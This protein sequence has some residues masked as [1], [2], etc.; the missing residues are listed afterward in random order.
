MTTLVIDNY[1]S[2]TFNVVQALSSLGASVQ[3][4]R[5]DAL[6]LQDAIS[7]NPRNLVISPGPG[8]P[9]NSGISKALIGHFAGKIPILGVCLGAYPGSSFQE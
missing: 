1:D 9:S 5:N 8:K 3:V 6:T 2:F 4:F 7:L